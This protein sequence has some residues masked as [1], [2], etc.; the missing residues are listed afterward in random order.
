MSR[1]SLC[2]PHIAAWPDPWSN[3]P[4]ERSRRKNALY[5]TSATPNEATA[6]GIAAYFSHSAAMR[7]EWDGEVGRFQ[8]RKE[9][10]PP[11][12]SVV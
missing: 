10:P 6:A 5:V 3:D 9:D 1:S 12:M 2:S 4:Q 11:L 7:L 8:S